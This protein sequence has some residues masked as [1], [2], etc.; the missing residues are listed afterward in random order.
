MRK[1]KAAIRKSLAHF[2]PDARVVELTSDASQNG[3][4]AHFA[5]KATCNMVCHVWKWLNKTERDYLQIEKE[6]YAIVFGCGKFH[7]WW[8]L[9][10]TSQITS[11]TKQYSQSRFQNSVRC[12]SPSR[13][14]VPPLFSSQAGNLSSWCTI[15]TAPTWQARSFF[16]LIIQETWSPQ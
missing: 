12:Y 13:R 6:L 11:P 9:A 14:T 5:I 2:D 4:G 16:L 3:L 15:Q 7:Y 10:V 8:C 1:V